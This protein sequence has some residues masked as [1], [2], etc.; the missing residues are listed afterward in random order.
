MVVIWREGAAEEAA[1]FDFMNNSCHQVV[2][3]GEARQNEIKRSPLS[4]QS[5]HGLLE[6]G[7]G[8]RERVEGFARMGSKLYI[9]YSRPRETYQATEMKLERE[10]NVQTSFFSFSFPVRS[11]FVS[12]TGVCFF[13]SAQ[14][15]CLFKQ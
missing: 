10:E 5:T 6:H 7:A 8:P 2:A 11:F 15:F 4:P 13:F 12:V 1:G 9:Y 14:P 3:S